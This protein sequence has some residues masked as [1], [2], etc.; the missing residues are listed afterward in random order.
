MLGFVLHAP[1]DPEAA[2][3]G[4]PLRKNSY[5]SRHCCR[6]SLPTLPVLGRRGPVLQMPRVEHMGATDSS[7]ACVIQWI[8]QRQ[9]GAQNSGDFLLKS[10]PALDVRL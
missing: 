6:F 8:R 3:Y 5:G 7:A 10:S 2:G 4:L 9:V 1:L